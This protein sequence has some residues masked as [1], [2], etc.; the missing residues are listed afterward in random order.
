MDDWVSVV[1]DTPRHESDCPMVEPSFRRPSWARLASAFAARLETYRTRWLTWHVLAPAVSLLAGLLFI[2]SA[3]SSGGTDLRAGGYTDLD[4]LANSQRR[5]V[6]RLRARAAE[7]NSEVNAL[8]ADLG[9]D[10]P[11]KYQARVDRLRRPAGL[12]PVEGPGLTVTLDD[13]PKNAQNSLDDPDV[14]V[15]DL[16]VHQQDIQAVANALWAGGAEA[17]TIQGQRVVSTTG[18]KCVGNSVVLHDVPYAPPYYI[19]AI[20]PTDRMF[21]SLQDTPWIDFYLQVVE[22]YHLG[23]NVRVESNLEMPGF[24]GP[25]ELRY[26]RPATAPATS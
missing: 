3:V 23:W 12:E 9:T 22:R 17:M 10:A 1:N 15:S 26:A 19:S 16:L 25:T 11:K 14:D 4:G 5:D 20:G 6:E 18:I 13:A 7:L 2:T 8:S 21:Q 24:S